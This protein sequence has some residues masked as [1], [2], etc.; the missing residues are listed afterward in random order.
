MTPTIPKVFKQLRHRSTDARETFKNDA[1]RTRD[2]N[3]SDT[4]KVLLYESLTL[5]ARIG[6]MMW[7]SEVAEEA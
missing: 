5:V 1:E 3:T 4:Q 2:K 6:K 7:G